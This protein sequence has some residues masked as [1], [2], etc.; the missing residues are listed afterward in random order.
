MVWR[1]LRHRFNKEEKMPGI[2][3]EIFGR[4]FV[5][6]EIEALE[7]QSYEPVNYC[8]HCSPFP[9]TCKEVEPCPEQ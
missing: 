2:I 9:C 4:D 3:E 5:D 1:G 6:K 8:Q 7:N